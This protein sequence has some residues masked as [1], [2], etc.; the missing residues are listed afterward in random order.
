MRDVLVIPYNKEESL[1][2]ASD[3][4]G[5]I[6]LKHDD[7]I[8]VSYEVVAYY[9]LRVSMM[10]CIAIGA[11][12]LAIILQNFS[13]D[14]VWRSLVTGIE[15]GLLELD[16]TELPI[17]GSTESNFELKQ[18]A[19]AVSVMGKINA[20]KDIHAIEFNKE[21]RLAVIGKPL[22]GEAV[23]NDALHIAPLAL[24]SQLANMEKVTVMPVGSKGIL[25]E[26]NQ[27]FKDRVFTLTDLTCE[28]D[29]LTSSGPATCFIISYL[30]ENEEK[31]KEMAT[32]YFY[33][34]KVKA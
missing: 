26:L 33:P 14:Q 29:L 27:L 30:P 15:K 32:G 13:G 11:T 1:V 8:K 31:I 21:N 18:S 4:S 34:V 9:A 17:T 7:H 2:I 5:G 25:A 6:G 16:M 23:I 10:E 20:S 28:L 24:C 12:P 3:N 19:T 22:V